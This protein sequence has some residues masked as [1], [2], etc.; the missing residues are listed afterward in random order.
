MQTAYLIAAAA[1]VIVMIVTAIRM[2]D[3]KELIDRCNEHYKA[4]MEACHC[5]GGLQGLEVLDNGTMR[6]LRYDFNVSEL[7][8]S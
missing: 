3:R 5:S 8:Q 1:L 7:N 6:W 4:Q 2:G